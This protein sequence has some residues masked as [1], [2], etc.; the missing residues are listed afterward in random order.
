MPLVRRPVLL[1]FA[2]DRSEHLVQSF[3]RWYFCVLHLIVGEN[4]HEFFGVGTSY[5]AAIRCALSNRCMHVVLMIKVYFRNSERGEP[6]P[7]FPP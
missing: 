3:V 6:L 2:S 5:A 1:R 4:V 7:S